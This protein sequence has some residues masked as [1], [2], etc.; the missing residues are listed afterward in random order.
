MIGAGGQT[1]GI[2][3][4]LF[5]LLCIIGSHPEFFL[6]T[7]R[8]ISIHGCL[9]FLQVIPSKYFSQ[10]SVSLFFVW[11]VRGHFSRAPNLAREDKRGCRPACANW[12]CATEAVSRL[13]KSQCRNFPSGNTLRLRQ[14]K[15]DPRNFSA[16]R[17]CNPPDRHLDISSGRHILFATFGPTCLR[18]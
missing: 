6:C 1:K 5:C 14:M 9:H 12:G 15:P 18:M 13:S 11:Y 7:G 8:V 4:S 17:L 3:L 10:F 2:I 16:G